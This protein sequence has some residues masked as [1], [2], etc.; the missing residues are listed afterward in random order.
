MARRSAQR[1]CSGSAPACPAKG[2]APAEKEAEAAEAEA[3]EHEDADGALH[4]PPFVPELCPDFWV[5]QLLR[6][7]EEPDCPQDARC[8]AWGQGRQSQCRGGQKS[9]QR[10]ARRRRAPWRRLPR[11]AGG[12]RARAGRQRGEPDGHGGLVRG[13]WHGHLSGTSAKAS[14]AARGGAH[15]AGGDRT[16]AAGVGPQMPLSWRG[17]APFSAVRFTPFAAG[18]CVCLTPAASRTHRR[19]RRLRTSGRTPQVAAP[20]QCRVLQGLHPACRVKI[21]F[22]RTRQLQKHW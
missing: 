16:S 4:Q 18:P 21:E 3:E 1:R 9:T 6:D 5:L 17:A 12:G 22:G 15:P 10:H 8:A 20:L 13:A 19:Q 14:A 2:G 11:D 7:V